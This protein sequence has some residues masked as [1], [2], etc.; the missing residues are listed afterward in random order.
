M[1]YLSYLITYRE[2]VILYYYQELKV[3]EIADILTCAENTVKTRLHRAR[4]MLQ[5]KLA[6][7]EWEVLMDD[8]F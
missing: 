6:T 7:S 4:K 8:S 3:I 2:V 5:E 1:R